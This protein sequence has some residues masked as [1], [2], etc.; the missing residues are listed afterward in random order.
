MASN[1]WF[2]GL[3]F[4]FIFLLHSPVVAEE[5]LKEEVETP[6]QM[7][8][9]CQKTLLP[10][11]FEIL[12]DEIVASDSRP[13]LKLRRIELK[14][15]SQSISGKKLGHPCVI[16][17]PEDSTRNASK[18]RRGKIVIV[19]QRSWDG[20]A[21]GPWRESFLGNYGEPIA[22]KMGYPT[23][24]CPVPGEFDETPGREVSMGNFKRRFKETKDSCDHSY[25]RLAIVYLR[26]IDVMADV[27]KIDRK[28]VQAVIGGHSKRA[29]CAHV[30]ATVD[31]RIKGVVYMG[32][33]SEWG[34][35]RLT[36]PQRALYPPYS[37]KWN[38]AKILYLGATNEDGYSMFSVNRIVNGMKPKWSVEYIPNYRHASQSEKHFVDWQ[39]WISHVFD[40]RPLTSISELTHEEVGDDFEWGGRH[41]GSGTLFKAKINSPNKIIQAKVWYVYNDDEPYWRD[42]MWYPEF[43]VRQADGTYAGFVKGKLPDAYLIEVKD[44]AHG[45]PGYLSSLPKDITGK[46]VSRRRS[47][48]SRSRNW[49]PK[50]KKPKE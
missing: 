30:A 49:T 14:F 46:K 31:P 9:R 18:D 43:M 40:N 44:I 20:L 35:N 32:N 10:L 39:M 45:F 42:L 33:E 28:E 26:A 13:N 29:T 27:L 47:R 16:F 7:W 50:K 17:L 24:I 22:A 19:G 11:N 12:K 21:T 3:L 6:K 48:G 15:Y 41:Y 5:P 38:S 8:E 1:H 23:M 37:Q 2:L 36:G 34:K 4:S 25:F